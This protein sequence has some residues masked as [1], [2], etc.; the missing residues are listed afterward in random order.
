M[1]WIEYTPGIIK[2]ILY[3]IFS[4]Y[5]LHN[6]IKH[7]R[8]A[9]ME[10]SLILLIIYNISVF[11][12]LYVRISF[13]FI[14]NDENNKGVIN[15]LI[16]IFPKLGFITVNSIL[17][18]YMLNSLSCRFLSAARITYETIRKGLKFFLIIIWAIGTGYI[19]TVALEVY[20][21]ENYNPVYVY[22]VVA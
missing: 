1:N 7:I 16:R 3:F 5:I 10:Y 12:V 14:P 9:G 13:E 2:G 22:L 21:N 4:V 20:T 19:I 6:S 17:M 8:A 18:D 15:V 11:I